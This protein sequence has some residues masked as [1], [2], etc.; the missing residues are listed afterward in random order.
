MV[1]EEGADERGDECGHVDGNGMYLCSA[2]G[3]A[4]GEKDSGLEGVDGC[5]GDVGAEIGY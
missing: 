3:V 1:G 2:G 4:E 5:Y